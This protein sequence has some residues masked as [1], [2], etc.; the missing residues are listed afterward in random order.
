MIPPMIR[1]TLLFIAAVVFAVGVSWKIHAQQSP[2]PVFTAAQSDAGRAAYAQ[3]CATCHGENLDDGPFAPALRG[4]EFR[5]RWSQKTLDEFATYMSTKMPPDRAGAL[6]AKT[7]TALLA[8][9]LEANGVQPGNRELSTERD[10]LRAFT[11]PKQVPSTQ[12]RLRVSGLGVA[13]DT[14]LPA[15][16]AAPNPLDKIAPVTDAMLSNPAP[17]EWLTWRRT[18][19]DLGFSP[20]KQI[21]KDNVKN[22]RV[23]WSLSLPAG[24]NEATPLFHDGVIFVHSYNDN[25]QALD[26]VTGNEL[27][28]YARR[29]P[30]GTRGSTKRNMALY[31]TKVFFGTSDLH[32]VALDIK[33]GNVVW[34]SPVAKTGERWNL[35]GG[36]LV[37]KGKVMQGIGGQGRGGAYI[38]ALDSETGKETWR[39]Y[40]VARPDEPGGNTWNGLPLEDRS[41]G[42]V[43]TAGSYDPE[44]NLAFFGPAPSYDTGPLR[45]PVNRPGVTNDALYT[46]TTIAINPDTGKLVWHYQHVPNDQWDLDWAFERQ[47]V[48]LQARKLV[49][50][51]GKPGVYDAVEAST[52]KY[53]FSF[54][55]GLQNIIT[56]INPETGAKTINEKLI[57]GNG[58]PVVVCPHAVGGRNWIPGAYNPDTK[59]LYVPA[60]ETCMNMNPVE[61]GARGFLSTGVRVSVI[62][63]TESDGRYGRIQAIN[64]D[65]KKTVWTE[66]QRAPQSTGVLATA[67]G[68]V[69]AGA[70]DRWFTAY[71]DTDGKTLWKIR[72][73]DVPNS[74][75]ITYAVNGK[76]Y[77]AVVVGYGGV[78]PSTFAGLI[79]EISLPV[80]RSSAIWVFELP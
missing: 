9:L 75:P 26:A 57:P 18:Y 21:T 2:T 36:P 79:P 51:A 55:M 16:P 34:D 49:I 56:A 76:Q 11:I 65:T 67:G 15:W 29:L 35:T 47:I 23:A 17:G 60:V 7:Y 30:E 72:L 59:I 46:D 50:T 63:R 45:N 31:G 62:P 27:W 1:R 40:T 19:D 6:E 24:P 4:I 13:S 58:Q 33:T 53:A 38:T 52:G 39:F 5:G 48:R 54:D 8:F 41:G 3:N 61:T 80:A 64:L 28:H 20:L 12:E 14:K 44:L 37:A 74:T 32:L 71:N 25:V 70:L 66:R 42:S 68:V 78:Q 77:V 10:Q 73:N 22:L 69:F 43:W